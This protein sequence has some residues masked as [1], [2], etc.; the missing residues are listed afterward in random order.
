MLNIIHLTLNKVRIPMIELGFI[1]L[2]EFCDGSWH[3]TVCNA[4]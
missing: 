1:N 3:F 2:K 4:V